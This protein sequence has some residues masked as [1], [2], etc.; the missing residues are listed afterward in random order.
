MLGKEIYYYDRETGEFVPGGQILIENLF[1]TDLRKAGRKNISTEVNEKVK[2]IGYIIEHINSE[3]FDPKKEWLGTNN[4]MLN[5]KTGETRPFSPEFMNTTSL[6][7]IYDPGQKFEGS[8]IQKFLNKI[9]PSKDVEIILNFIAY[10][11]WREYKF[12]NFLLLNGEGNNGK[13]TLIKLIQAFM[14][15]E[16]YSAESLNRL[17][18]NKFATSSLFTKLANFDADLKESAFMRNGT[19]IIKVLTGNDESTAEAKFMND[20]KFTNYA[21]SNNGL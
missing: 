1:A 12:A 6:P 2:T 8:E 10:C 9:M 14:G 18:S 21:T 15:R 7:I 11:L 13:G 17:L 4:C 20:F 5:V 19:D 16:N 3:S